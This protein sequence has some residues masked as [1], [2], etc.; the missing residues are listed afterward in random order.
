M[1]ILPW[2]KGTWKCR[3]FHSICYNPYKYR[4][5]S[6]F[7]I[8][9]IW[10][11]IWPV[12]SFSGMFILQQVGTVRTFS[13]AVAAAASPRAGEAAS[14]VIRRGTRSRTKELRSQNYKYCTATAPLLPQPSAYCYIARCKNV[15]S[16]HCTVL[17]HVEVTKRTAPLCF[18]LELWLGGFF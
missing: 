15:T 10:G 3:Y 9:Q 18:G 1:Y 13:A 4:N 16:P 2:K 14:R 5:V 8:C 12:V 7:D 11:K 6:N 17:N